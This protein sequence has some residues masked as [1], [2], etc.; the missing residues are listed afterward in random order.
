[1]IIR[2]LPY[3]IFT[4]LLSL[5]TIGSRG[6]QGSDKEFLQPFL[7]PL[8]VS[9]ASNGWRCLGIPRARTPIGLYLMYA[10]RVI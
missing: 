1:M 7:L 2:H 4:F 8:S 5:I 6:R 9:F 10:K 3:M